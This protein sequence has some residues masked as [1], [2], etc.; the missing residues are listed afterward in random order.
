MKDRDRGSGVT[1]TSG[2]DQG[3]NLYASLRSVDAEKVLTSVRGLIIVLP[4]TV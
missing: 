3:S 1:V 2:E 4:S